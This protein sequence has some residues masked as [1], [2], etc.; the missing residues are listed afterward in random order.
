MHQA[1]QILPSL[2]H[3]EAEILAMIANGLSSKE[4]AIHIGIAPR[5][6]E[7]HIENVR[8]KMRAR[9]RVQM[10]TR[11]VGQGMLTVARGQAAPACAVQTEMF[12]PLPHA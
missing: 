5:T 3:R 2:T 11:A 12:L 9:N 10:V 6:V 8:M 7:R 4:A 1:V